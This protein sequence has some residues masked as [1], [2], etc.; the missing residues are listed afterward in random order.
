ME[1]VV[2]LIREEGV[3]LSVVGIEANALPSFTYSKTQA[4][5]I[6]KLSLLFLQISLFLFV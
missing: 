5:E 1:V 6:F 3:E 2:G 4:S